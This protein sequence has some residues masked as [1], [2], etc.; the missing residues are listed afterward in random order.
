M[1][2][3][4]NRFQKVWTEKQSRNSFPLPQS[5]TMPVR[6]EN[7]LQLKEQISL[8][9]RPNFYSNFGSHSEYV[10]FIY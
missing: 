5:V 10:H 2:C 7:R 1:V 4:T 6:K 8:E 3:P 9:T